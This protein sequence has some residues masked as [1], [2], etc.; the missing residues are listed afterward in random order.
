MHAVKTSEHESAPETVP[1][2]REKADI[3]RHLADDMSSVAM[4]EELFALAA[5][6]ERLATFAES[7]T[8]GMSYAVRKRLPGM[9][10]PFGFDNHRVGFD[11]HR[12]DGH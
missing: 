2:Y 9:A 8:G 6:Y 12:G 7:M 3:L 11:N 1:D 10:S 4:R 5:G